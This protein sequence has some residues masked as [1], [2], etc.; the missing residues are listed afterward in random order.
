MKINR[1]LIR[2]GGNIPMKK[3]NKSKKVSGTKKNRQANAAAPKPRVLEL[4]YMSPK[5]I[6]TAELKQVIT[7]GEAVEVHVWPELDIMEITLLSKATVDV[8]TM[9]GFMEEEE[10]LA[11]MKEHEIESVYAI[12]I[13]ESAFE[14]F[15]ACMKKFIDA[16]GGFLCSDSDDFMPMYEF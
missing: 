13:E 15:G 3:T 6:T 7:E 8:E 2:N 1:L 5:A 4:L 12:T 11:F 14:E 10:D 16:Y 9:N